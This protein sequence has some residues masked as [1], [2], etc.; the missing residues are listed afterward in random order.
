MPK[1]KNITFTPAKSYTGILQ[2]L[3]R[4]SPAWDE[5]DM[6]LLLACV[7]AFDRNSDLKL[8][9]E[10]AAVLGHRLLAEHLC[11]LYG[12]YFVY[13]DTVSGDHNRKVKLPHYRVIH[14]KYIDGTPFSSI[15]SKA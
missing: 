5:G 13:P 8:P 15:I 7:T 14:P 6:V 3:R 10:V 4:L 9:R 11:A 12:T 1:R 2:A